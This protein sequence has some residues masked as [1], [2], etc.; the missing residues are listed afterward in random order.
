MVNIMSEKFKNHIPLPKNTPAF[1]CANCGAVALNPDSICKIQ[2]KVTKADWCGSKSIV[3]PKQCK[4]SVNTKRYK[5][6]KCGRVSM[7]FELLCE[8]EAI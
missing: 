2:G 6:N 3:S 4:N 7:N 8:P 5:C 1:E